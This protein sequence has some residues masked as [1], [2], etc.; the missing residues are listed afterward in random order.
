VTALVT[1]DVDEGAVLAD[2]ESYADTVFS[3]PATYK[4]LGVQQVA[5]GRFTFGA[6]AGDN[7]DGQDGTYD[8]DGDGV[9]SVINDAKGGNEASIETLSEGTSNQGLSTTGIIIVAVVGFTL[10]LVVIGLAAM[11]L[12]KKARCR[13][14]A[15]REL[16]QE[17]PG[18][19]E[20]DGISAASVGGYSQ[21]FAPLS[22]GVA[23]PPPPPREASPASFSTRSAAGLTGAHQPAVILNEQD[24]IS[25]FSSDR[26]KSRFAPSSSRSMFNTPGGETRGS[27]G[28][29]RGS[30]MDSRGSRSSKK[31][32]EFVKAGQS[33]GSCQSNVPEDTVD[34]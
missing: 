14:R 4:D 18:E 1:N 6:R 20:Y 34:L 27:S 16:F 30:S 13:K 19:E 22:S 5:Y 21:S 33:F 9:L 3:N 23:P 15:S 24:D 12:R 10:L 26:S 2:I 8:D 17:F 25:L 7:G 29:T 32:V 28:L 31:S 11:H